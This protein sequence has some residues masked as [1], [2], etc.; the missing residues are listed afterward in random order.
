MGVIHAFVDVVKACEKHGQN[1]SKPAKYN[2][3][4][5][6]LNIQSDLKSHFTLRNK[7]SKETN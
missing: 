1:R 4:W 7:K 5:K 6:K 3:T 2:G